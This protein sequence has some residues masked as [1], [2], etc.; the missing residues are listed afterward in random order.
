MVFFQNIIGAIVFVPFL[1]SLPEADLSHIGMG[2]FYGFLIGIVVF[3]L[4]F[5]GLSHLTASTAT[6][7]MYLE[8]VS[9][10]LLGY[11]VL[12]EP[13]TW[14]ILF[15]GSLIITSSYLIS[16]MNKKAT[17]KEVESVTE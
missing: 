1:M 13:L 3:K 9:A 11:L 4:F 2:V 15:G 8:V 5:Y 7:L 16:R 10:I 6:T 12:G 17:L 14:N